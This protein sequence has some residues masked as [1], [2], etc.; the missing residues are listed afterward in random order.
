MATVISRGHGIRYE[1]AGDGP[2][3]ILV[4]GFTQWAAQWEAAG[5]VDVLAERFRVIRVDPL[6]HGA[7]DKPHD[8]GSYRWSSV[9]ADLL[10]VADAEALA[11][12]MWWGFSRGAAMVQ[13]LAYLHPERVRAVV[14]GSHTES[15]GTNVDF[16]WSSFP[17]QVRSD[18]GLRH[19]W[20]VLGFT[21]PEGVRI[22]QSINDGEALACAIAGERLD[23][24]PVV[25]Q[26]AMPALY[27]K[28]ALEGYGDSTTK[29][30]TGTKCESHE[31]PDANHFNT[32][33]RSADVLP[34]VLPFLLKSAL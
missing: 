26:L 25:D 33:Q 17:E 23:P 27:Y 32:F 34:F 5:Y 1:S 8:A 7:S 12:P 11:Q 2:P 3:L 9:I 14:M 24:Y 16:D 22:G 28:G 10:A 19:L 18:D 20:E 6:G 13:D 15:F 21:D 29:L 4:G 31:V 30:L